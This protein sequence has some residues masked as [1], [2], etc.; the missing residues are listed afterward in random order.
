MLVATKAHVENV[1]G[2]EYNH[3]IRNSITGTVWNDANWVGNVWADS[4][5]P[6]LPSVALQGVPGRPGSEPVA[7]EAETLTVGD[8]T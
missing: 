1:F 3:G 2:R 4:G 5:K 7:S 8:W 6:A